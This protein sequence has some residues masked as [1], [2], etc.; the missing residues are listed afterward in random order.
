MHVPRFTFANVL[1]CLAL[2]VALGGASYAA[3]SLPMNSV[4]TKQLKSGAIDNSKVKKGSL[5]RNSFKAG[6]LPVGKRG[7]QGKT[8]LKGVAGIA[9]VAG[10][11]GTGI[12]LAANPTFAAAAVTA[13]GQWHTW[14]SVTVTAAA[15][16]IYQPVY[17]ADYSQFNTT[18]ANC[19]TVSAVQRVLVNGVATSPPDANG[20]SY[21]P[22]YY[23]TYAAGT[24]VTVDYQ[25]QEMCATETL[26]LP[27]GQVFMVPYTTA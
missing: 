27:A 21:I 14:A 7:K 19:Q 3:V 24:Q 22:Q 13:D 15:N 17:N 11:A 20:Y 4:G 8:G 2:F 10:L 26:H 1:S 6:Q 25:Y 16:T 12:K 18:G 9:G 23:G 5:L